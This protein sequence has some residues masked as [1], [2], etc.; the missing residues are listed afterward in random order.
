M[1]KILEKYTNKFKKELGKNAI[2]TYIVKEKIESWNINSIKC[3][4]DLEKAKDYVC[5]SKS[6]I[7][8]NLNEEELEK[9][10]QDGELIIALVSAYKDNEGNV[11]AFYKDN[12]G[13]IDNKYS[14]II[15]I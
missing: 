10:F 2:A 4:N 9:E 14:S 6:M 11:I 15:V 13:N 8:E 1:D 12:E 5:I 3:F 7:A